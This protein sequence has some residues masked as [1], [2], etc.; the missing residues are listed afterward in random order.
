MNFAE[1]RFWGLLGLG[2]IIVWV[3]R[4]L[5]QLKGRR[6]SGDLDKACLAG[7]GLFLLLCV[8]WTT[9][10]IFLA[11]MLLTYVGVLAILRWGGGSAFWLV[12]LAPLQLA[13]LI[14]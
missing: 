9:F 13:P 14:Y 5:A 6:P 12:V 11:V 8:S 3:I 4:S 2:L 10:L 7:L 1:L